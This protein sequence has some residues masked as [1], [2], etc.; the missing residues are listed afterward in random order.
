MNPV[1]IEADLHYCVAQS[2]LLNDELGSYS[3]VHDCKLIA[4]LIRV[5][6]KKFSS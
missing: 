2:F 4:I 3:Y 1:F 6:A 5:G